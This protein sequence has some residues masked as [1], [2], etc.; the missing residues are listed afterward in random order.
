MGRIILPQKRA[1][2]ISSP[3]FAARK[4]FLVLLF[5]FVCFCVRN[6]QM[7]QALN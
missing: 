2:N 3:I 6:L 1:R 7:I 4:Y 5:A